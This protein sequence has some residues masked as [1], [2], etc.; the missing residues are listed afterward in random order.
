MQADFPNQDHFSSYC[1][2]FQYFALFKEFQENS[3]QLDF[4]NI[5]FF[6]FSSTSYRLDC[7]SPSAPKTKA[8]LLAA[9]LNLSI[10][11]LN[12]I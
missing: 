8:E 2:K 9:T 7:I 10:F 12:V 3:S 1:L 6:S 4:F 5:F 11:K